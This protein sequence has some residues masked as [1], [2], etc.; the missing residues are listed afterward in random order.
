MTAAGTVAALAAKLP[1]VE[2]H[3][4]FPT[5]AQAAKAKDAL[6]NGWA[7]AMAG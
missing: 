5:E 7:A 3:P 1:K 4:E 2:E 6:A